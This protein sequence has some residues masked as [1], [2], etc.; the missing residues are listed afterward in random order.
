MLFLPQSVYD[1]RASLWRDLE[2]G[3]ITRE[4]AYR[5]M[6]EL[7]PND[8]IGLIGLGRLRQEA[9]DFAAAEEYFWQAIQAHPCM[10]HPYLELSRL[11]SRHPE[12]AALAAA[13]GELAI[14]KSTLED[15]TLIERLD[16][17]KA[18][19]SGKELE[20]FTKLDKSTQGRLISLAMRAERGNEPEA[21]TQRLRQLRLLQQVH[22]DGVLDRETVDAIIGEGESIPPLLVGVL[23]GWAQ[24]L[25]GD[26]SDSAV[27]NALAL[28][29][30][31]GSASEISHLLDFVDL[32]HED[33]A[34]AAAWALGRIID[35][36]TAESARFLASVAT[37]LGTAERIAVA[38]QILRHPGLDREGKLLE[39]LSQKIESMK[40][41]ER[42]AFF[43]ALLGTM[44]AAR[45]QEGVNLGFKVLRQQG[46]LLPR[47]TRRECEELLTALR[48][49]GV[50]A[51]PMEPSSVTVYEICAGNAIWETY[52]DEDEEL[53]D[54]FPQEPVRRAVTPGR[55][56]PCW[57]NSGKKYK[58]CHL[59]SDER[60][61][62]APREGAASR[63]PN[64]F[65]G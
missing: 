52:D 6:L 60:Q 34:G 56:D 23:R 5:R 1:E 31:T 61:R 4:R 13:I 42:E 43:P 7:D 64:E 21:V 24:D 46:S 50:S 57:C 19:L 58:K 65:E 45:G 39:L 8:H 30:E 41:E 40:K 10:S 44:A 28:L 12:S 20:E 27:E 53:E 37:G 25:L 16:F 38:E 18:G 32:D 62:Q 33:V 26:E 14:G 59:D 63:R 49:E 51:V 22:E 29:G 3:K 54:E 15:E 48:L 36:H 47:D 35:R 9:G 11:L 17:Q 55:N 2:A